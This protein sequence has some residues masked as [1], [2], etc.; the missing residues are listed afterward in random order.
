MV[1]LGGPDAKKSYHLHI[2]TAV[3]SGTVGEGINLL[4]VINYYFSERKTP[5]YSRAERSIPTR[6]KICWKWGCPLATV[7]HPW[8][9][10]LVS[11][12]VGHLE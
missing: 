6:A 3:F 5:W 1:A 12:F 9:G 7:C 10:R 4:N 8:Y 11:Q 2:P